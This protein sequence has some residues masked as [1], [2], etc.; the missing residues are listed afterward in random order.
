MAACFGFLAV[1]YFFALPKII[2]LLPVMNRQSERVKT[3]KIENPDKDNDGIANI[4]ETNI[5]ETDPNK[6]DTNENGVS[7]GEEAYRKWKA[8]ML[9]VLPTVSL[10]RERILKHG[11]LHSLQ[12]EFDLKSIALYDPYSDIS[13][14]IMYHIT[15]AFNL[16]KNKEFQKSENEL[17]EILKLDSN[18]A[19]AFHHLGLTYFAME[20]FQKALDYFHKALDDKNFKSPLL[21]HDLFAASLRIGLKNDAIA[22][23]QTGIENFPNYLPFYSQAAN[24]YIENKNIEV[25]EALLNRGMAIEP[26]Y[27]EFLNEL[28]LIASMRGD[29]QKTLEHYQKAISHDLQDALAHMNLSIL[30]RENL[31]NAQDSLIEALLA[32]EFNP[33]QPNINNVLGLAY[34]ENNNLDR[35]ITVY[36]KAI[37]LDPFYD[38]PYNNIGISYA[39]KKKYTMA[40]ESF[41][42]AIEINPEYAKAYNN[43]GYIYVEQEKYSESISLLKKAAELDPTWF[44]PHQN[45]G[46]A[47]F[48]TK[49]RDDAAREWELAISL[50]MHNEEIERVLKSIKK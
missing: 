10:Y 19:V 7:D 48:N 35:A 23:L 34:A 37:E 27:A 12:N 40:Q 31:N 46:Y 25:A 8:G 45:L 38:K 21:Y 20:D 17:K 16:R 26:R 1:I 39:M 33:N 42:K 28:G 18:S 47:Y 49:K 14:L 2:L 13:P 36:K 11:G 41:Q 44:L 6:A 22:Y 3:A 32:D 30:Y 9:S 5:Y 24:Y 15:A 4:D 43:L 29:T 50:G